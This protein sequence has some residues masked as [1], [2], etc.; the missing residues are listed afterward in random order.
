MGSDFA[1]PS[2]EEDSHASSFP[3]ARAA[4]STSAAPSRWITWLHLSDL[5]YQPD[6]AYN[7]DEVLK[8]LWQD[9]RNRRDID[10]GLE[11]LD[12]IVFTGDI[13]Y[14]GIPNEYELAVKNFIQPL[15][16]H[17]GLDWAQLF[18][19]PGNHDVCR[20]DMTPFSKRIASTLSTRDDVTRLLEIMDDDHQLVFKRQR[21]YRAFFERHF[22]HLQLDARG[23]FYVA[24]LSIRSR[25]IAIIG[26]NSAWSGE[27]GKADQGNLVLG[28][29]QV[30]A[31]LE[32]TEQADLRI[33]LLHHP[34][35]WLQDDNED[36][37]GVIRRLE[38]RC[39]VILSGHLHRPNVCSIS[40]LHGDFVR[41]PAGSIYDKRRSPLSYNFV[42][43]DLK[44]KSGVVYLRR[45]N[46]ERG[47]WQRDAYST[48]DRDDGRKTI[49]LSA[50]ASEPV[51]TPLAGSPQAIVADLLNLIQAH[52]TPDNFNALAR[53]LASLSSIPTYIN[54]IERQ[55][56]SS[57]MGR[58]LL[59][60]PEFAV[61][62]RELAKSASVSSEA[63]S[64]ANRLS[65]QRRTAKRWITWPSANRAADKSVPAQWLELAELAFNPF[66]P[67]EAEDDPLL[68]TFAVDSFGKKIRG[69][70][71]VVVWGRAGSGKSATALL[72][73]LNCNEPPENPR[74]SGAFPV[75]HLL[76]L[77]GTLSGSVP[78]CLKHL[79][80]VI[81][82]KLIHYLAIEPNGLIELPPSHLQKMG[83]LLLTC[84]GSQENLA[85]RFRESP[86]GT[87]S[88]HLMHALDGLG[89]GA[90]RAD[91]LSAE[92]WLDL[93]GYALPSEFK[94]LYVLVDVANTLY[95]GIGDDI[96]SFYENG[97]YQLQACL[98]ND[99]PHY[100]DMLVY[101]HRLQENLARSRQ[102][103]ETESRL[104]ERS[105]ILHHLD[106]LVLSALRL[107]FD[108]WC[109]I[110]QVH[111]I[112]GLS[113][114]LADKNIYLKVFMPESFRPYFG[115][116]SSFNI[117]PLEWNKADLQTLLAERLK[118]ASK[119]GSA[120]TRSRLEDF[121]GPSARGM[122]ID[123]Q[124]IDAVSTPRGLVYWGNQLLEIHATEKP[125]EPLLIKETVEAWQT[126]LAD[127][128]HSG[129]EAQS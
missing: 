58:D 21:A 32:G 55:L 46:D 125:N 101:Q 20:D 86:R 49:A 104:A 22:P 113:K 83:E 64:S 69:A 120:S 71:P 126:K 40:T 65:A 97:L 99:E 90:R 70:W 12:F 115:D 77:D 76:R 28:E 57:P 67:I 107:S 62:L 75:Y 102:Y 14:H 91:G 79:V 92:T 24:Q 89:A 1:T 54:E 128:V 81:V 100:T 129:G 117:V 3:H 2:P 33:V 122:G 23:Y 60:A 73:A 5:H 47:E 52:I 96:Y 35:D 48:G 80:N 44:S 53:T 56:N 87:V 118:Q 59:R 78:G 114:R 37:G 123:E 85:R 13:T 4:V 72:L 74:E 61:P 110:A 10:P 127:K 42:R 93:L 26:L 31:A 124:L 66:G 109:R 63:R 15:F 18:V 9:L 105:E 39:E 34:F 16:D 25:Q 119:V 6:D 43:F 103:G 84:A 111:L 19:V 98:R 8:A 30:S 50:S 29:R 41:I 68:P 27:G 17:T 36:T 38:S 82:D 88:E 116:L 95:G 94:H 45:Y 106:R 51:V 11:Q 121:C 112:L 7:R 108:E